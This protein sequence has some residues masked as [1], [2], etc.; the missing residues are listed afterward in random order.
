M[1]LCCVFVRGLSCLVTRVEDLNM[2][3]KTTQETYTHVSC[4]LNLVNF[5][6]I[7]HNGGIIDAIVLWIFH[8][9]GIID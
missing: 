2:F 5:L 4:V 9:G 8:N 7:F 3:E 1:F 6:W